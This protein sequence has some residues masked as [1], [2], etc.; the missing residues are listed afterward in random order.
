MLNIDVMQPYRAEAIFGT[1][2]VRNLGQKSL[3]FAS[4]IAFSE[5]RFLSTFLSKN[6]LVA[7]NSHAVETG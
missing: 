6:S 2:S 1:E 5:T 4:K 3:S 7:I